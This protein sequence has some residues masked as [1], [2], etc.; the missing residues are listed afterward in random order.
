MAGTASGLVGALQM[1]FGAVMTMV[2]YGGPFPEWQL[3]R[4]ICGLDEAC[5]TE[6]RLRLDRL[7]ATA[8]SAFFP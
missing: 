3:G 6:A 7:P 5:L 2:A 1:A 8:I 4:P